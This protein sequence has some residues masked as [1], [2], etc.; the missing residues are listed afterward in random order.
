MKPISDATIPGVISFPSNP[1]SPPD[2]VHCTLSLPSPIELS[3]GETLSLTFSGFHNPVGFRLLKLL[4]AQNETVFVHF[5]PHEEDFEGLFQLG[6]SGSIPT[7]DLRLTIE[8]IQDLLQAQH[9]V[10]YNLTIIGPVDVGHPEVQHWRV[11]PQVINKAGTGPWCEKN[12]KARAVKAR[13]R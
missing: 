9:D 8:N 11:D 5:P 2:V 1:P 7:G 4:F 6:A 3:F 13:L 12:R 10:I